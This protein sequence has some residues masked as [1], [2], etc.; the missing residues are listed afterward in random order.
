MY[1]RKPH[2]CPTYHTKLQKVAVSKVVNSHSPEARDFV[3]S[4]GDSYMVGNIRF[5]W[6]E[7]EC[8]VCHKHLSIKEMKEIEGIKPKTRALS[9]KLGKILFWIIGILF[10]FAVLH[11][12]KYI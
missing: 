6:D 9:G 11:I 2:Y 10:L 1:F 3:F 5:T 4:L 8:P 7:F 12:R